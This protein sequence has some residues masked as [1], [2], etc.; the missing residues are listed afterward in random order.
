MKE[1][2]K[3]RNEAKPKATKKI[4]KSNLFGAQRKQKK[5]EKWSKEIRQVSRWFLIC[6]DFF[7]GGIDVGWLV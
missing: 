6:V 1:K 2:R 5:S 4:R 3:I 7:I